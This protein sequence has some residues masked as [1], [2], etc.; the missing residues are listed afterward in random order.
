MKLIV[1]LGNPGPEYDQTRHNV[2]F[3]VLDRLEPPPALIDDAPRELRSRLHDD[4][5]VPARAASRQTK[6]LGRRR[7]ELVVSRR[8]CIR[9]RP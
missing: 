5:D 6:A 4:T 8:D 3:V 9:P 7:C 1:G 2:G